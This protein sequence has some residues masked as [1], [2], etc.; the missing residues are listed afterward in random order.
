MHV[1]HVHQVVRKAPA[2]N[3]LVKRAVVYVPIPRERTMPQ[4]NRT[5]S[6]R[7]VA[8]LQVQLIA[9][10][11]LL[12]IMMIVLHALLVSIRSIVSAQRAYLVR[13][14]HNVTDV[15]MLVQVHV[16]S[17]PLESTRSKA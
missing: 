10:R 11:L 3:L 6:A 2:V 14:V 5:R 15:E 13:R 7:T 9:G 8:E 17:V 16:T 4:I 1:H 12:L